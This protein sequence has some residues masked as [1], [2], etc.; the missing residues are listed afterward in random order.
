M[1][2]ATRFNDAAAAAR[3]GIAIMAKASTPGR[4]KTRLVPPLTFGEAAAL[5]TAFLQDIAHNVLQAGRHGEIAGYVAF[6]PHGSEDFFHSILPPTIGLIDACLPTF[7][8]C[9]LHTIEHLLAR[10]HQ[11]RIGL[12]SAG[13]DRLRNK[14]KG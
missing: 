2:D 14:G 12:R 9:L 13:A 5:N 3:C 10:G 6:A 8:E 4:T 1:Q 7:G 11:D